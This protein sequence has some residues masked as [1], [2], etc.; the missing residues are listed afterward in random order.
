MTQHRDVVLALLGA[1]A[2]LSGLVLV[3]LGFV[4]SAA[5]GFAPGT[6]PE[7]VNR[8]RRP[9]IAVLV[10]FGVGIACVGTATWW[11]VLLHDNRSLYLA[12]VALFLAQLVSVLVATG[13]AVRR[14]LWG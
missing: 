8:E 12:T 9:A 10:S 3:F 14:T 5:S 6:K 1:S 7:I 4:V 2:G 11:L 13:W